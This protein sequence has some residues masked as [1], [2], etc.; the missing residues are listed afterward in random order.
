MFF[1]KSYSLNTK[2]TLSFLTLGFIFL[3]IL[4]I[5]IIPNLQEEQ[6]QY[7][8]REIGH[9]VSLTKEQL[10]LAVE[11]LTHSSV[12]RRNEINALLKNLLEKNI[13]KDTLEENIIDIKALKEESKC[14]VFYLDEKQTIQDDILKL[15]NSDGIKAYYG[16]QNH[17]CPKIIKKLY[18]LKTFKNNRK[19]VLEC[20]PKTI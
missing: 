20:E 18:Y 2:I 7:K 9:M 13:L 16:E 3:S 5:Q 6:E 14:D 10:K 4:F 17:M 12:S 1:N 8:K 15:L 11:L 19:I